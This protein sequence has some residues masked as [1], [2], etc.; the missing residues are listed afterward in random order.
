MAREKDLRQGLRCLRF[1][2]FRAPQRASLILSGASTL[3]KVVQ[4]CPKVVETTPTVVRTRGCSRRG[5]VRVCSTCITITP[6]SMHSCQAYVAYFSDWCKSHIF[7]WRK[8]IVEKKHE[9][10]W[11]ATYA[12]FKKK[13]ATYALLVARPT[14]KQKK[15]KPLTLLKKICNLRLFFKKKTRGLRFS[16]KKKSKRFTLFWFGQKSAV[17]PICPPMGHYYFCLLTSDS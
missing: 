11:H 15:N 3:S 5:R 4:S 8:S 16:L 12:I 13:Y 2:L 9:N 7:F 14:P 10:V 1:G 17:L 6:T